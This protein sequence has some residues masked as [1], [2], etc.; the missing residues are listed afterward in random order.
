M[1]CFIVRAPS[2]IVR[3]CGRRSSQAASVAGQGGTDE[4][5]E[6]V[7]DRGRL[8]SASTRQP[9]VEHEDERR[10]NKIDEKIGR[11]GLTRLARS[12]RGAHLLAQKVRDHRSKP[13][14][15]HGAR[16]LSDGATGAP[17]AVMVLEDGQTEPREPVA[18][19]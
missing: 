8:E 18:A 2:M 17:V 15:Q 1:R 5:T 13:F 19:R 6:Q 11:D 12:R 4:R 9:P 16:P 14:V 10:G 7:V 3:L